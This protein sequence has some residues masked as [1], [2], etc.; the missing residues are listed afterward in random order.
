[1]RGAL[2]RRDEPLPV[3][4]WL[5]L[6]PDYGQLQRAMS[7]VRQGVRAS[8]TASLTEPAHGALWVQQAC[9]LGAATA[10]D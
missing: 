10:Y 2:F 1:M 8:W 6:V 5:Q 7:E 3:E 9:V 4:L